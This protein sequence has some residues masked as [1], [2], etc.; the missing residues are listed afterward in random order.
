M[1][2]AAE[3]RKRAEE[4]MALVKR[5]DPDSQPI[6]LSIAEAWLALAERASRGQITEEHSNAPSTDQVQ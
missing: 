5:M 6:L 2:S 1:N 3:F 4:C